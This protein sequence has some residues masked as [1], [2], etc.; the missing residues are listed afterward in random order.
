MKN[1]KSWIIIACFIAAAVI[2]MFTDTSVVNKILVV[3]VAAVGI[4]TMIPSL[5]K[6]Q[7]Q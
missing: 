4:F 3:A 6:N 5:T 1:L 7:K 2:I